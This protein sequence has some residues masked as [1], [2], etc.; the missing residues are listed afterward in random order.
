[1]PIKELVLRD[2]GDHGAD[3]IDRLVAQVEYTADLCIRMLAPAEAIVAVV[4]EWLEDVAVELQ[5]GHELAQVK[6]RDEARG[7]WT[8]AELLPVLCAL[9]HRRHPVGDPCRFRFVSDRDADN[10]TQWT[11]TSLGPLYRLKHL[12]DILADGQRLNADE[13]QE[14]ELF[15]ARLCPRMAQR[16]QRDHGEQITEQG[17][18]DLLCATTIETGSLVLRREPNLL[19]LDGALHRARSNSPTYG[20]A[21][22]RN[23]FDRLIVLILSRIRQGLTREQRRI[24]AAEVLTCADPLPVVDALPDLDLLPG[25]TRLEKKARYGGFDATELPFVRR[26]R[27]HAQAIMRELEIRGD[28]AAVDRFRTAALATH[29]RHRRRVSRADPPVAEVGPT[30]LDEAMPDLRASAAVILPVDVRHDES[31]I[32]GVLWLATEDCEAWWHRLPVSA[33]E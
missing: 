14:L 12:L 31:L 2:Y 9:F 16:L 11:R 24:T 21:Q 15:R 6:T 23:I 4:P 20:A 29:Q 8:T 33:G 32:A 7:P 19:Q 26:Q 13:E 27:V 17:A 28:Q 22:L 10:R 1:M 3:T 18:W 30:I 25:R 5:V